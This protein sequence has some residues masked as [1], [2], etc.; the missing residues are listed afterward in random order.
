[1]L[2]SGK[3]LKQS[4]KADFAEFVKTGGGVETLAGA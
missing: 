1:M 2:E 3:D 4:V